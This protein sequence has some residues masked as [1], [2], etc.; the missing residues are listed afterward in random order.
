MK[1]T[2]TATKSPAT[3]QGQKIFSDGSGAPALVSYNGYK[4]ACH[5]A[6]APRLTLIGG[7]KP[8]SVIEHKIAVDVCRKGY[9]EYIAQ[10][11]TEEWRALN[12]VMYADVIAHAAGEHAATRNADCFECQ[13]IARTFPAVLSA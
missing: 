11:T 1:K 5:F 6:G 2:K 13:E 8:M 4:F 10:N 9:E 12:R 7:P 3:V